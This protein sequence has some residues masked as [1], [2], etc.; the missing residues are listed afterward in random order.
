MFVQ[1]PDVGCELILCGPEEECVDDMGNGDAGCAP[2][3]GDNEI[4][5]SCGSAC[6]PTCDDSPFPILCPAVCVAE[7]QC[8]DGY[9]RDSDGNCILAEDCPIIIHP[10]TCA[11]T[12]CL[13]GQDCCYDEDGNGGCGYESDGN[14]GCKEQNPEPIPIPTDPKCCNP[15]TRPGI[16]IFL[17]II[18]QRYLHY[19]CLL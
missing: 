5:K 9:K 7:C 12:I 16:I 6:P 1:C 15:L 14:G 4:F 11:T 10:P 13:V 8:Q 3:C 2:Q 18:L 19:K 17:Y